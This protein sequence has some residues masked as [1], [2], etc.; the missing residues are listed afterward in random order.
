MKYSKEYRIVYLVKH[1]HCNVGND[2]NNLGH[3]HLQSIALLDAR[4]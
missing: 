3:A 4:S 1:L 2:Y